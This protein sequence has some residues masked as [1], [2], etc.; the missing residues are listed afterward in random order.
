MCVLIRF[1]HTKMCDEGQGRNKDSSLMIT[2]VC[3]LQ[4]IL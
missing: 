4:Y 1:A 2:R 3:V